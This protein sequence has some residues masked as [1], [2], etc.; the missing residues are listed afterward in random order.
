M[1]SSVASCNC[2]PAALTLIFILQ[3]K[4]STSRC[5]LR[6][7]MVEMELLG[8]MLLFGS[9]T[10]DCFRFMDPSTDNGLF[11]IILYH[12]LACYNI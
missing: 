3:K 8:L 10:S 4:N 5:G 1:A 9:V 11:L 6:C 12:V 2:I 7:M